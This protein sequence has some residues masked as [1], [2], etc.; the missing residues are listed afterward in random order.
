LPSMTS[1]PLQVLH[2]LQL[3][4]DIE[5]DRDCSRCQPCSD[6]T[7]RDDR[8]AL[9]R[10]GTQLPKKPVDPRRVFACR[11][12]STQSQVSLKSDI[13][14]GATMPRMARVSLCTANDRPCQACHRSTPNPIASLTDLLR[15]TVAGSA[16]TI[17]GFTA[18]SVG[19]ASLDAS[20]SDENPKR[21]DFR[22]EWQSD[23]AIH[24]TSAD[25][26]CV[27]TMSSLSSA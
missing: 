8:P 7:R 22:L 15:L 1:R 5:N 16:P 2:M 14:A 21:N 26:R 12:L 18:L 10:F 19:S 17:L 13:A 20:N 11:M 9:R 23:R 27:M 24:F 25:C 3:Q 4:Y 6:R